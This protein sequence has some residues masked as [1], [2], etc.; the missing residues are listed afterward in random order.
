MLEKLYRSQLRLVLDTQV[1]GFKDACELDT[2]S[3]A[4]QVKPYK[5]KW[6][7]ISIQ[8]CERKIRELIG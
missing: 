5:S 8:E 1:R 2:D 7:I 3:K 6:T 4:L